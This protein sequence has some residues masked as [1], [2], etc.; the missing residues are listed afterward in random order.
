MNHFGGSAH[1]GREHSTRSIAELSLDTLGQWFS[2]PAPYHEHLVIL[3]PQHLEGFPEDSKVCRV[4]N[5]FLGPRLGV[6]VDKARTRPRRSRAWVLCSGPGP[7]VRRKR[8][9]S[10]LGG[11]VG[12]LSGADPGPPPLR[13]ALPHSPTPRDPRQEP[14]EAQARSEAQPSTGTRRARAEVR[15]RPCP[16]EAAL[17]SAGG[18]RS[19]V[20]A[21]VQPR[22]EA[23]QRPRASA[24]CCSGT[25][26]PSLART[27]ALGSMVAVTREDQSPQGLG[28]PW[29]RSG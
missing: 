17:G 2:V 10:P 13:R 26:S 16:R 24:L 21:G 4:Q 29:W 15:R 14:R 7:R 20:P 6:G 12:C 19:V 22:L 25:P 18:P 11:R 28:L 1:S 3:G 9:L 27:S 5:E 23:G 8:A